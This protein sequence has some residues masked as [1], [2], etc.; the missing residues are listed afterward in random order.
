MQ[1]RPFIHS[2]NTEVFGSAGSV[3]MAILSVT[4]GNML[5]CGLFNA[6]SQ[7]GDCQK[8]FFIPDTE[9]FGSNGSVGTGH[10]VRYFRK[11]I[12]LGLFNGKFQFGNCQNVHYSRKSV[13]SVSGTCENL[14]N[15]LFLNPVLP[16]TS[17]PELGNNA[18]FANSQFEIFH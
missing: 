5:L 8:V 10:F 17:V 1:S 9:V 15:L 18:H 13:I 14:C 7:F 3:G 16:K 11:S 12:T 2:L 6:I 4:P